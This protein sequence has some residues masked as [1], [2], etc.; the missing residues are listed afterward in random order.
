M[1]WHFSQALVEEYLEEYSTDGELFA[2]LRSSDMP[3]A[4]CWHDK[5]TEFLSL[6]QFGMMS[7]PLRAKPGE[8]LL[9]WYREGFLVRTSALREQCGDARGYQVNGPV[10]G[11]ICSELLPRFSLPMFSV[12]IL[13]NSDS[14]DLEK[15]CE[16]LPQSGTCADGLLWELMLSDCIINGNAYGSTLPTPTA[17][18]WKDTFGMTPERVD[19]K[20]RL[21]RLPMLLFEFARRAGL[22]TKTNWANTDAQTVVLMDLVEI[23]ITGPDY[24]PELPEWVM[25]WP[26]GWTELKP[27][28]TDRF[29]QWLLL[30]GRCYT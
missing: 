27:L 8:D 14:K 22:S 19:G 11:G 18:D 2:Q 20:T 25:G 16:S 3:E 6:F 15:L 30:H 9:K 28:E 13:Q 24:C 10:Y 12:K 21:D 1:S 7:G 17:R 5:M 29:Q 23:K 4:Y 26:V